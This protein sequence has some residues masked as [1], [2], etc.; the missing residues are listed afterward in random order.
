MAEAVEQPADRDLDA[1]RLP[2][3]ALGVENLAHERL[4]PGHIVVRHHVQA[5]DDLQPALDDK[6]PKRGGFLRIPIE[7]RPEIGRL[8]EREPVIRVLFQ[9]PHRRQD[10]RQ[11][12]LQVLFPGLENRPLPMRVGNQPKR[13]LGLRPR[14]SVGHFRAQSS[15]RRGQRHRQV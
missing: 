7:E 1:Q 10:M 5:A 2:A 8:V 15:P 14:Q 6:L 11:P 12:H 9:Q 4:A 13:G 3:V